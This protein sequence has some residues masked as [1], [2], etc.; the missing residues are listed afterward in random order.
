M[1]LG[2]ILISSLDTI[3]RTQGLGDLYRIYLGA[4]RDKALFKLAYIPD[5]F[6]VESNELF[7]SEY[8]KAL[9]DMAYE[10]ARNGYDWASSPPGF[11]YVE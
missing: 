5:D 2:S 1:G 7:D 3:I 6:E 4:V 9:F 8:M 10:Q 11:V